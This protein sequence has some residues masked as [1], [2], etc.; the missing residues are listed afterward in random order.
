MHPKLIGT[1]ISDRPTTIKRWRWPKR[2]SKYKKAKFSRLF[3][4]LKITFTA[5]H[6]ITDFDGDVTKTKYQMLGCDESSAVF[7]RIDTAS[8]V[9]KVPDFMLEYYKANFL[10]H[11]F[12][13]GDRYWV[14]VGGGSGQEWFKRHNEENE[15]NQ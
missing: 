8:S 5:H 13:D 12:F 6:I 2:V 14:P 1:W 7:K 4:R 3:G 15:P 9:K 10:M 11:V